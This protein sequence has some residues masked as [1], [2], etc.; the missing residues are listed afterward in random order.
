MATIPP[1]RIVGYERV[2]KALVWLQK[3]LSGA[4]V[5]GDYAKIEL[6]RAGGPKMPMGATSYGQG[7]FLLA[8]GALE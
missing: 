5:E 8:A 6:L 2:E 4:G 7:W 1:V 3:R